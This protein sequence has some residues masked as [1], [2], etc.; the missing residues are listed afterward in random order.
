MSEKSEILRDY[1]GPKVVFTVL[2]SWFYKLP[3]LNEKQNSE[4]QPA[5]TATPCNYDIICNPKWV[6]LGTLFSHNV[7]LNWKLYCNREKT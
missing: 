5:E 6:K 2:I 4:Q 1:R 7:K 3:I